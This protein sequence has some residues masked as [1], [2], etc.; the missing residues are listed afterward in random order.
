[1]IEHDRIPTLRGPHSEGTT[2]HIAI[3]GSTSAPQEEQ[4][5]PQGHEH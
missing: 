1:L 4:K 2:E 3:A 5:G